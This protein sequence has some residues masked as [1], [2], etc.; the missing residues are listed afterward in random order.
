MTKPTGNEPSL[1]QPPPSDAPALGGD[2]KIV[3]C[4][5]HNVP[6]LRDLFGTNICGECLKKSERATRYGAGNR[7]QL[8]TD[9]EW[10]YVG[11]NTAPDQIKCV[12][13]GLHPMSFPLGDNPLSTCGNCDHLISKRFGNTYHKC[14]LVK[15][16]GSYTTDVRKKWPGCKH[17]QAKDG[18]N[19]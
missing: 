11:T 2:R 3:M 7:V 9:P 1:P 13:A 17:W 18:G 4:P 6:M 5:K 14:A 16:T 10:F 8:P 12:R 19:E 15:D